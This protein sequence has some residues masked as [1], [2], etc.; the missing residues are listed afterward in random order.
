[1]ALGGAAK[2]DHVTPFFREL[3]L[4][5]INHQYEYEILTLTYKKLNHDL[6]DWLLPL[7]RVRECRIH[8]VNTRGQTEHLH[9]PRCNTCLTSRSFLL[10]APSLWY[11]LPQMY[12]S[13]LP[14]SLSN[15]VSNN[16]YLMHNFPCNILFSFYFYGLRFDFIYIISDRG[17]PRPVKMLFCI[18]FLYYFYNDRVLF[19]FLFLL[20]FLLNL[21]R[22][23]T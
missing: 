9:V 6:S 22:Y 1:M 19:Y 10:T 7:V 17:R 23:C 13:P 2:N 14:S 5:K 21:C 12:N 8:H 15:H 16:S 18:L 3:K 11:S 4:L 20:F